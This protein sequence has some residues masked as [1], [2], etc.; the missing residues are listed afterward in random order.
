MKRIIIAASAFIAT[1]TY[2][3]LAENGISAASSLIT[4]TF[5]AKIQ[6]DE[7]TPV[8]MEDLPAAVRKSLQQAEYEGWIPYMAYWIR[9]GKSSYYEIELAKDKDRKVV[10]LN[11]KGGRII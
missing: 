3:Q 8:K 4:G 10:K 9:E 11:D 2:A 5:V 7:K 6:E 1:F